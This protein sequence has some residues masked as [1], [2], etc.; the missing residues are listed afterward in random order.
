ME[1]NVGGSPS[2]VMEK[3]QHWPRMSMP[4]P[5]DSMK[6]LRCRL[7]LWWLGNFSVIKLIV[8]WKKV[9]MMLTFIIWVMWVMNAP[10]NFTL[11]M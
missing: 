11:L 1:Q 9:I 2:S 4:G 5:H 3:S 10:G 7:T 8:A 6:K